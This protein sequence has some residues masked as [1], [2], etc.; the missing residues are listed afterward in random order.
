MDDADRLDGVVERDG[1]GLGDC[2]DVVGLELSLAAEPA[3]GVVAGGELHHVV[4]V[5]VLAANFEDRDDVLVV[6]FGG[7]LGLGVEALDVLGVGR[8]VVVQK[9]DGD[10]AVGIVLARLPDGGHAAPSEEADEGEAF[11]LGKGAGRCHLAIRPS[12]PHFAHS[13]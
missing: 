12:P 13:V 5:A 3:A 9:L 7:A 10:D 2:Q 11:E 6:E 4:V 8:D 1:D